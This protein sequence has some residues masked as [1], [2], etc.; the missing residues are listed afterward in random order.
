VNPHFSAAVKLSQTTSFMISRPTLVLGLRY[1]QKF[2][3]R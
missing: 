1:F 3:A 2:M